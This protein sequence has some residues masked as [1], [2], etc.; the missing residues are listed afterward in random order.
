MAWAGHLIIINLRVVI[1][2]TGGWVEKPEDIDTCLI[3]I[4]RNFLKQIKGKLH[5]TVGKGTLS[6]EP[7]SRLES[8]CRPRAP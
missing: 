5:L 7:F 3:C 2:G 1:L 8:V 6:H 4:S